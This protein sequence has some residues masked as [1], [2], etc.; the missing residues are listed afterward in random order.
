MAKAAGHE[1][2][3]APAREAR[4]LGAFVRPEWRVL[5]VAIVCAVLGP[6]AALALPFAAKIVVDDVVGQ[7]RSELLLPVAV[8]AGLAVAVQALAA[9]GVAQAGALA[10]QRV[11]A[12]LRQRLQRHALRLPIGF[13]DSTQTGALVSRI[14]YD[15]E[16][17][18]NL[19]GSGV[20][21]LVSGALAAS[22]AFG[23]LWYLNW[24]L[25]LLVAAVLLLVARIL[26]RRFQRLHPP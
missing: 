23:V 3:R 18:R 21:Q 12:R 2:P 26:T 7:G 5:L 15:T 20:L 1:G 8:A 16:Q 10:G 19:L 11:V 24:R 13:F 14:I 25:T 6:V 17:V 9:Y 22:L 4:E